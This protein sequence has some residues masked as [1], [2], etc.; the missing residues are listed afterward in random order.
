[1]ALA[2]F[3]GSGRIREAKEQLQQVLRDQANFAKADTGLPALNGE[4]PRKAASV[5]GL[6]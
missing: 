1:M 2:L 5:S 4:Q 6:A 3:N